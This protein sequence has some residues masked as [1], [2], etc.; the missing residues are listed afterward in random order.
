MPVIFR[1]DALAAILQAEAMGEGSI[2]VTFNPSVCRCSMKV[3]T[4]LSRT[5]LSVQSQQIHDGIRLEASVPQSVPPGTLA[6]AS[7][8]I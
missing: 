1:F 4:E 7:L 8:L 2:H 5:S 6:W 3:L